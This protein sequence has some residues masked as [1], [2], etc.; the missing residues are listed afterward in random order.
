[1]QD[2]THILTYDQA[3]KASAGLVGT[4]AFNVARCN[5]DGFLVPEGLVLSVQAFTSYL[6]GDNLPEL[7]SSIEKFFGDTNSLIVRSSALDEDTAEASFA[8]QYLS[9]VCLNK[10]TEIR[11]AC[12]ACWASY[13]SSNVKA[14]H[15]AV[16]GSVSHRQNGM[17]L[18][19]QRM[20]NASSAGVCFTKDPLKE[21]ENVFIINVVHG[22]GE[23]LVA[24]EVL[25]D[26]YAF[27]VNLGKVVNQSTGNQS[28]WRSP[29][30]PQSLTPLPLELR[31][32]PVLSSIQIKEI[33][34]VS[35]KAVRLFGSHQ[36]IEWVYEGDKLFLLQ[37][38]PITKPAKNIGYELWTRDNVADVIPDVV[39]PLTW[40]VVD[41][42]TN[43]GF[44]S[45]VQELGLSSLPT[46]L[47]KLFD[48][49]VYSNQTTYQKLFNINRGTVQIG[50]TA[51]N[52][53][54]LLAF[55]K[56]KVTR[57]EDT[58]WEGF[59]T[60]TASGTTSTIRRLKRYLDKYMAIHI[61]TTIMM[62]LGF[63][64]IRKAIRKYIPEDETSVIVDGLVTGLKEIEST[65]SGEALWELACLI[66]HN[67]E[68]TKTILSSPDHAIPTILETWGEPY[69]KKWREFLEHHGYSSLKEFEIY[70][71]RWVEDP[72]FVIT[73]LKHYIVNAENIDQETNKTI[74]ARK[75]VGSERMLFKSLPH[76]Y[77]VP[78]K[79]YIKHVRQCSIWRES[80]KQKLVRIMGE[81]RKLA[82]VF[83]DEC[84]IQPLDGVF[85][86]TIE[87]ISQ[88]KDKSASPE[89]FEK[90]STRKKTWEKWG[91]Q[92]P[93]KEIRIYA[94]GR[95]TE[96]P[97][98]TGSGNNIK[99]LALSSGK[100]I[101]PA[102][103]ILD[104]AQMS[105]FKLGDILVTRSTNPS[106]TPLFALA[107]AILTDMGNYLSHGAIVA[108]EL[109]IPAVGNLLDAT[110]RIVDGQIIEVDADSG[111]VTLSG[112]IGHEG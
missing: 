19:I 13:S 76:I 97:Y 61:R 67:E 73:N 31:N 69:S 41:G 15:R 68:L 52:Y 4:K 63:L 105:S 89:L 84:S 21:Q 91:K 9:L 10:A 32:E 26:Q 82:L 42:P 71:P 1:L 104:L 55:L 103:V 44:K 101:G 70:Y 20:L 54:H 48:G 111:I 29:R 46:T 53:L 100:Y 18:L 66:N 3:H 90:I 95:Q 88:I 74:R 83:A 72:S 36:D 30:S 8:G 12:E 80:I 98:L 23:A 28:F 108:R 33:A 77:H 65:A 102:R 35:Q 96:I 27:H 57:A 106:W 40:S 86:L 37:A 14:Y 45:V 2:H 51:L 43:N 85:F 75:R 93:F 11:R 79:F 17:G 99:G 109:G 64:I 25:A 7:F 112:T 87:E 94:N 24:G 56:K 60:L 92:E 34:Q 5:A 78:L 49:R 81:I 107:G 62:Q 110:T 22:L 47:F 50:K 38:R 16:K 58:F 59:N 39:T 6:S